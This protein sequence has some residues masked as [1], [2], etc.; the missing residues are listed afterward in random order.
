MKKNKK[1]E[2]PSLSYTFILDCRE[3]NATL[4]WLAL[5]LGLLRSE[6]WEFS[7]A[8]NHQNRKKKEKEWKQENLHIATY[9][10]KHSKAAQQDSV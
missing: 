9:I 3:K 7:E 2:A 10:N 6:A 5:T 4:W 1:V 8:W